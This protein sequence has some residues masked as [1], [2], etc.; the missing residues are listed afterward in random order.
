[1]VSAMCRKNT[2]RSGIVLLLCSILGIN[3]ASLRVYASATDGTIDSTNRYAW[4]ENAGWLDFGTSEGNV[5]VTDS[6]LTGYAWGENIGWISLNCSNTDSCATVDYKV[7]NNSEGTLGGNAWSENAGW[8]DFDPANGGVSISSSGVFSGYAWGELV[9]WIVFNCSDEDSC[10]TVDYQVSTDWRP[11]SSRSTGSTET[12]NESAAALQPSGGSRGGHDT[13]AM[14]A[15]IASA[16]QRLLALYDGS[17]RRSVALRT[18]E[19]TPLADKAAAPTEEPPEEP[20]AFASDEERRLYRAAQ[21]LESKP[22]AQN[23]ENIAERRGRLFA[24]VG[25]SPVLYRD[26]PIDAWYAPYVASLI[27]EGV[28]TGYADETGKPKGE[29]GVVNPVTVA[30]VLKMALEAAGEDIKG[31]APPR[32]ASAKGTWASAYVAKAEER[33]L[34]V[35]TPDRDV[36]TPALRGEVIQIVM[37]TMDILTRVDESLIQNLYTDLP[38]QYPYRTA[39]L[40]ATI[41]GLITGD[42]DENGN[43]LGTFRPNDPINRAE[44]AKIIALINEAYR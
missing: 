8:I 28:A 29:F 34:A 13:P 26:V 44:V 17:L 43:R 27:E 5:H 39:I 35:A 10:A 38:A 24:M 37:Q 14:Q 31:L 36:N 32:N 6:A 23:F 3:I 33:Q 2:I 1:M 12:E 40:S 21:K 19:E 42:I 18:Q 22:I 20:D 41:Q 15:R 30:E 11:S 7:T 25:D 9:G 4:T 16:Q